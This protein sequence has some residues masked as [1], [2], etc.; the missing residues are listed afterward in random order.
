MHRDK[1]MY[2]HEVAYT[3]TLVADTAA[4]CKRD[5]PMRE[6]DIAYTKTLAADA[7]VQC[8]GTNPSMAMK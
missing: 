7:A 4:R 6:H 1:P 2:E 8:K 3:K 5:K